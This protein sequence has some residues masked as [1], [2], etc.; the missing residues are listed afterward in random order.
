MRVPTLLVLLTLTVAGAGWAAGFDH[1]PLDHVLKTYVN[2]IGE[3]DYA[4]LKKN[5]D[6]L[7][8]YV[9]TLVATSPANRPDLF[10]AREDRLAYWLNAYNAFVLQA[11]AA[12]YPVKS[13]R[14]LGFLYGFFWRRKFV[15]GGQQMTLNHLEDQLIRKQFRNPRIHFVLVCASLSCPF[16][17]RQALV[18][19]A[20]EP[21]LE[22]SARRFVNQSRNFTID[23]AS[24]RVFLSG[25]YKLRNYDD[26]DFLPGIRR[27]NPGKKITML[28]YL[29]RYLSPENLKALDALKK[30]KIT[31]YKY[32]WS[33]NDLGSR[34][35]AKLPQERELAGK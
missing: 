2:A 12:S 15:A 32:D 6:E 7:D 35:R 33:I 17:L 4:A 3:V 13:V 26:K 23:A 31:F 19:H 29:R 30:P 25:V 9:E 5:P 24:N 20:L 27:R 34:A 11:V 1:A 22:T 14:K 8:R 28:H 21:Q 16:L 10:P 18:G